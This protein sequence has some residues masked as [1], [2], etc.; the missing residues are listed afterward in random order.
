MILG[1]DEAGRG[2]VLGPMLVGCVSVDDIDMLPEGLKDSKKLTENQRESLYEKLVE[3]DDIMTGFLVVST[4]EIDSDVSISQLTLEA[5]SE[6]GNTYGAEGS[7]WFADACL[8]NESDVSDWLY[9]NADFESI[10]VVAEHDA[11]DT[12]PI[13][14]AASVVAKHHRERIVSELQDEFGDIG[15]G[16]PSDATT[17]KFLREFMET[18]DTAPECAR[19]SWKTVTRLEEELGL[20]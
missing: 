7:V 6:L 5:M 9:E 1:F 18:H 16:Y 3:S 13:V 12:Y 2:P 14:S 4:D 15:S 10:S 8:R 11:D 19:L 20:E 17:K